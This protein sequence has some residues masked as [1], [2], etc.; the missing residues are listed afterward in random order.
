MSTAM[1]DAPESLSDNTFN[2]RPLPPLVPASAAFILL[3]ITAFTWD[4]LVVVPVIGSVLALIAYR[5]VARSDGAYGG[6]GLAK[7][8]VVTLPLMTLAA[9]GLHGYS[10]ATEVPEGFRRVS[11][12]TDIA[13]KGFVNDQ[14]Q[15][16]IHPDVEKLTVAPVFLKG[17]MYPTRDTENLKSFVLCKDSGDCC[18]G[19]QPK[20]TDMVYI[21]MDGEKTVDFRT[22]LVSVAGNFKASPTLDPT[23]L[24]PVYKLECQYFSGAKTSY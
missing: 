15:M 6:L 5:Q 13:D 4:L 18:F 10:Y 1:I 9:I 16:S 24:N 14:G 20:M 7:F 3:S 12:A 11:F 2:Y 22:G 8:C 17:Y 21:E 19:G 23:G